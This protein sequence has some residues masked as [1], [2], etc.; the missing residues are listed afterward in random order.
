M[1]PTVPRLV[2][3]CV[4]ALGLALPAFAQ[5]EIKTVCT[6][7]V[8]SADEKEVLRSHLPA[9]QYRFVEL[10]ERGRP[11]W[12][13][14]AC[15]QGTRCDVLVI[16]GHYDGGNEFFSDRTDAQEFLPVDEL[17]RVSCSESCPGLFSQLKEVH[18]FGCNTL[19]TDPTNFPTAEIVR[20]FVQSGRS[21]SD[22]KRT[23]L[24][25]ATRHGESS[26]DR[27]RQIFSGVPVIYGFPSVAPLGPAAASLLGSYLQ[28]NGTDAIGSGRSDRRLLS[29]FAPHGLTVTQGLSELDPQAE[30]RRDICRLVDE[31]VSTARKINFMHSILGREMGE[32]RM[33]LDRLERYA[34]TLD[35]GVRAQ[36]DVATALDVMASDDPSRNRYLEFARS[37]DSPVVQA[38]ML[39]LAEQVGWLSADERRLE[40]GQLFN[41][42]LASGT[43]SAADI[44]LV[45]TLNK[46]GDL[47]HLLDGSS[48]TSAATNRVGQEAFLACLGSAPH[49]ARILNALSSPDDNDVRIAQVYLMHRSIGNGTSLRA[50]TTDVTRMKGS[51]AQLRALQ[52]LAGHRIT[53]PGSLG[54]LAR[55]FPV[56]QTLEIQSAIAGILLRSDLQSIATAE[57]VRTLQTHRLKS[58]TGRDVIDVL[59]RHMQA[60]L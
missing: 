44:D 28:A 39:R 12:L 36:S 29:A 7:T 14:S 13:A 43:I 1:H 42:Q 23:A 57:L 25:L 32:V 3:V 19:N 51:P 9:G 21:L 45:C 5:S 40:L 38:R 47:D 35:N 6:I 58:V 54:E 20:S 48:I 55:L 37:A 41:L 22:A 50:A 16:S 59:I 24:A 60:K 31:R 18:L 49:Q 10:V 52:A 53:D 46:E 34:A 15:R 2:L 56:A 30:H 4:V 17:E 11:D 26:R 8:N 27:M 33:F